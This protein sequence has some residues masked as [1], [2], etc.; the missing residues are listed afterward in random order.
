MKLKRVFICTGLGFVLSFLISII[1][2]HRIG[3]TLLRSVIFAVVFGLLAL[4]I[5]FLSGKFLSVEDDSLSEPQQPQPGEGRGGTV[6]ITIGDEN[7]TD[8]GAGPQFAVGS[9]SMG[10]SAGAK[11]AK[12]APYAP[13]QEDKPTA[14]EIAAM[15]HGPSFGK[16]AGT[17]PEPAAS[18]A[19]DA[20]E[21][22]PATGASSDIAAQNASAA[23]TASPQR[24]AG[25]A[26]KT[27]PDTPPEKPE[28]KPVQLGEP[29]KTPPEPE[30][31]AHLSA[32]EQAAA[33]R[34]A[35]QAADIKEIDSLPDIGDVSFGLSDGS[36]SGEV[37]SDSEFASSGSAD[38]EESG[39]VSLVDGSQASNHDAS[40]MAKAIQT[41]L[42][43]DD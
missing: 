26:A 7:L 38:S 17:E 23:Q 1:A 2:T 5:D 28:F 9:G 34:K 30:H 13:V 40:T 18:A 20:A 39:R 42:K 41:L 33:E 6:D 4:G 35:K 25:E 32:K 24:S 27:E 16:R 43:K 8:D 3:R 21:K 31:K 36:S 29:L 22:S 10:F 12:P 14:E 11:K 19:P 15:P 37:I